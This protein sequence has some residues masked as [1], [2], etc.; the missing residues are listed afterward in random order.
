MTQIYCGVDV[1]KAWLDS[2]VATSASDG[3][4]GR[5]ENTAEGI[6]E[7]LAFARRHGSGLVVMEASGSVERLAYG[8][9]WQAD[10][11]CALV[12]PRNVRFYAKA[13][14]YLEKTDRIDARVIARYA[15]GKTLVPT[16][17]PSLAQQRLTALC[18][19]LSQVTS[20]LVTQKQRLHTAC[21][22]FAREGILELIAVLKAQSRK[23]SDEIAS[24]ID[25]DPLWQALAETFSRYKGVASRTV[26]VV[27]AY[28]PEIGLI[29]NRAISK[30]VG[31]A[32]LADDSGKRQGKRSIRG[33]RTNV[34]NLLFLVAGIVA[35]YQPDFIAFRQRLLL[36]GK[37]KMQVRIALAHKLIVRLNAKARDIR[38]IMQ[39]TA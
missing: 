24:M 17:P 22:T 6:G 28:L 9:L 33:G 29:S 27:M 35:K 32:P 38:A 30:L 19:R 20:D 3:V 4:S 7:L 15:D 13:M 12:N 8:L 39:I 31:L 23:L 5:F 21:E 10:M 26:A 25:D 2:Y 14:G 37:S 18:A 36:K 34:R 16:P 11:P 1:S